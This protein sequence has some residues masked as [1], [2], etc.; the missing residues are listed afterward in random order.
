MSLDD[1]WGKEYHETDYNCSHFVRDL[2]LELTGVD[3][4]AL[5]GAWNSGS[6]SQAMARRDDLERLE[7]P[8]LHSP[9]IALCSNPGDPPHVGIVFDGRSMFHM[10]PEG[11]KVHTLS[12]LNTCYDAIKYYLCQPK[13]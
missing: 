13:S 4:S 12:Y 10:T 1:F 3:I 9:C 8:C 11:P 5:V 6:L 7:S 2:W